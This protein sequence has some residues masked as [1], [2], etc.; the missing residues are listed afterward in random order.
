MLLTLIALSAMASRSTLA[1]TWEGPVTIT[2]PSGP[3]QHG[4]GLLWL[5]FGRDMFLGALGDRDDHLTPIRRARLTPDGCEFDLSA[6]GLAVHF[7]VRVSNGQL[8][9]VGASDG[10][11]PIKIELEFHSSTAHPL[12]ATIAEEDGRLFDAFDARDLAGVSNFFSKNLEFY[13]DKDGLIGY[14][15]MVDSFRRH[16]AETTKVKRVLDPES[17]EVSPVR[18]YGA[19]ESGIHRFYS[20]E[21]GKDWV[22][23][24]TA[25]FVNV[26]KNDHGKWRIFRACSYDHE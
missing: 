7:N 3:V 11:L 12:F 8:I 15:K 22:L 9:G 5:G 14:R 4:R 25:K 21:P 10:S 16:F 19:I 1:G 23:S 6:M 2:P 18:G 20:Q 17:L 13:H 24:A 26:W